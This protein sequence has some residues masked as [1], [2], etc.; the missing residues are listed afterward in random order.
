MFDTNRTAAPT[1]APYEVVKVSSNIEFNDTQVETVR[2]S[3]NAVLYNNGVTDTPNAVKIVQTSQNVTSRRRL[4]SVT[5]TEYTLTGSIPASTAV[6]AKEVLKEVGFDIIAAAISADITAADPALGALAEI[7]TDLSTEAP[8][9]N[10]TMPT[11]APPTT[12]P[13]T[14]VPPTA[15]VFSSSNRVAPTLLAVVSFLLVLLL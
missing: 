1:A 13:P 11:T 14:T 12:A 5:T 2:K 7:K 8:T 10:P 15:E 9:K 3:T 4:L 6:S